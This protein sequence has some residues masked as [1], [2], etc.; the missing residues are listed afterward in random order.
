MGTLLG[1]IGNII[2]SHWGHY[3]VT[4]GNIIG[5]HWGTLLGHIGDIIGSHW[6]TLSTPNTLFY[7]LYELYFVLNT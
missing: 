5:S 2:G 4:L 7:L 3:W 6:G 1:H